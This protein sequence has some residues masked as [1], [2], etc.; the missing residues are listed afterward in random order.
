MPAFPAGRIFRLQHMT[1]AA[2]IS[3]SVSRSFRVSAWDTK[4]HVPLLLP[5]IITN[6]RKDD[7]V[8]FT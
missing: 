2:A 4:V 3:G 8:S 7:N 1:T 6:N 5:A